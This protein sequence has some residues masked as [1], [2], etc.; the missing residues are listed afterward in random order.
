MRFWLS[1]RMLASLLLVAALSLALVLYFDFLSIRERFY[2][3]PSK[4]LIEVEQHHIDLLNTYMDR[5]LLFLNEYLYTL[6]LPSMGAPE[7]SV[8]YMYRLLEFERLSAILTSDLD[9]AFASDS[10]FCVFIENFPYGSTMH[11]SS[12]SALSEELRA[13][14]NA[15]PFAQIC[16]SPELLETGQSGSFLVFYRNFNRSA[17][18]NII[19][20]TMVPYK[21]IEAKLFETNKRSADFRVVHLI[22]Q[23]LP[24]PGAKFRVVRGETL[25]DGSGYA[26][27]ISKGRI[28]AA[29]LLPL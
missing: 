5:S 11:I 26:V 8:T 28:A 6:P 16:F 1:K 17:S 7:S 24:E 22:G 19:L 29:A 18:R 21:A 10:T 4:A 25:A 23:G 2:T 3:G 27:E 20:R 9:S 12:M 13:K 15:K 14:I